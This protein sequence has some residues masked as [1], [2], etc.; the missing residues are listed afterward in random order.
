M[1]CLRQNNGCV[2]LNK[3]SSFRS[4]SRSG[5]RGIRGRLYCGLKKA[6]GQSQEINNCMIAHE[7]ENK[8]FL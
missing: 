5:S 2:R 7:P 1:L 6:H 8:L 3:F 4:L